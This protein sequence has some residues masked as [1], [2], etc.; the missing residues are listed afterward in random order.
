[1][2]WTKFKRIEDSSGIDNID[3][4]DGAFI[5]TKDG[6]S[7]V[8][9]DDERVPIAGT[10]DNEMSDTSRNTVENKVIK[11]YVDTELNSYE[12]K[13]KIIWTNSNPTS[14]FNPQTITLDESLGNYDMYEILFLQGTTNSRI[15]TSGK[16]PVGHGT[17]LDYITVYPKFRSTNATVSGNTITF[18]DCKSLNAIGSH[19]V[20]NSS[21]IPMYVIAYNTGI[22]E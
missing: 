13:G 1:M 19:V 15:M 11:E 3:F 4:E 21:L 22:F 8:D 6:K 12:L 10:P 9:F 16:I 18:E 2:A 5:V 7:Y 14:N 17:I 20:E